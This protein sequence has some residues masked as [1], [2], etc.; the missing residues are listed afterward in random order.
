MQKT[1]VTDL[2]NDVSPYAVE[3]RHRI[4]MNPETAMVEYE[5]TKLI[6]E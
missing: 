6:K 2:A 1:F 4:L 5:T 3:I